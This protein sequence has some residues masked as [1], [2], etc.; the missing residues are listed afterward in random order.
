MISSLY[1]CE[2]HGISASTFH[3]PTAGDGSLEDYIQDV[4]SMQKCHRGLL[5][6]AIA[7]E[8]VSFRMPHLKPQYI[9]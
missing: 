8:C 4:Q 6:L 9:H 2:V 5:N 1:R 3:Q 7:V